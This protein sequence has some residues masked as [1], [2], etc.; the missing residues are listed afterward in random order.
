M[1]KINRIINDSIHVEEFLTQVLNLNFSDPTEKRNIVHN[2]VTAEGSLDNIDKKS[3]LLYENFR[4]EPYIDETSRNELRKIIIN[5]LFTKEILDR[6]EDICGS[7][8]QTGIKSNS[9]AYYIIGLPASGKSGITTKMANQFNA[10]VLDSDYAKRKFPEYD[11][12]VCASITH[13]E[14]AAVVFG[15]SLFQGKPLMHLALHNKYNVIIPKVGNNLDKTLS[16]AK[17]LK[18]CKY[19]IHL[20]LVR[21]DRLKATQRAYNR[22][23]EEKRYVR[24]Q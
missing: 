6:D 21:L 10:L 18:S 7:V 1:A 12:N 9:Q 3:T 20:I 5:E 4:D 22:F 15:N 8:P 11:F 2:I 19:D 23:L 14:S 24:D 17:A 13:D 16:L